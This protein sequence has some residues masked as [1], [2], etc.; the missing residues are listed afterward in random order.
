MFA[1]NFHPQLR[2]KTFNGDMT[3]RGGC[4]S[5]RPKVL[6]LRWIYIPVQEAHKLPVAHRRPLR[7]PAE[8]MEPSR[9][10][11]KGTNGGFVASITRVVA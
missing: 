4:T 10:Q 3:L 2:L 8:A 7:F 6:L 11:F 1:H 5:T 9:R